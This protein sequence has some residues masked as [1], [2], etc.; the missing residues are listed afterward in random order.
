MTLSTE[1]AIHCQALE[2]G[3]KGREGT[4]NCSY[5]LSQSF[6]GEYE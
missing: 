3:Q 4:N 6:V 1:A 5:L 2:K